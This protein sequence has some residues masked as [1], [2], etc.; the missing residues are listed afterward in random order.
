M[1]ARDAVE[2][3]H[4]WSEITAFENFDSDCIFSSLNVKTNNTLD[5]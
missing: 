3:N 5:I 1:G 4:N 2:V